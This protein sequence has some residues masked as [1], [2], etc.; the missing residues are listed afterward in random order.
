MHLLRQ[1]GRDSRGGMPFSRSP[2]VHESAC[3]SARDLRE[4]AGAAVAVPDALQ[5]DP[6]DLVARAYAL[7]AQETEVWQERQRADLLPGS[8]R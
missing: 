7:L 3:A 4:Q 6:R 1:V 2:V 8:G 5:A